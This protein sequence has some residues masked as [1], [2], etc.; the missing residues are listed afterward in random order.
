M[1]ERDATLAL[2]DACFLAEGK[3]V[4]LQTAHVRKLR[5]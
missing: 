3:N 2:S 4:S 5:T 1:F